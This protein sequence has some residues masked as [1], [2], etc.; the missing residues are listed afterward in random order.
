MEGI[1]YDFIP[2]VLH[3]HLIDQWVKTTDEPSFLWAR[4]AIREEGIL[5][6]GSSGSALLAVSN[7]MDTLPANSK[8]VVILADGVRNYMSKMMDNEWLK[9]NNFKEAILPNNKYSS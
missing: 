9:T 6:G 8:V 1:G 4:K 7:I 2:K 5:C 3:Q